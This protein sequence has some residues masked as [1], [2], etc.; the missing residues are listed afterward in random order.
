MFTTFY[1]NSVRNVV[2]AFGSLFNDIYVTRK[3]ADGSTKEKIRVPIAYGPKEKFIRRIYESSSIS[4]GPKVSMTLPRLSFELTS[5]DYD[6]G[7]KRNTMNKR[8]LSSDSGV[9][10]TSFDYS[11]VPYNFS[12]RLSAFV[13][14]MDDGLQIVEQI[15]PYFTPEFNVTVNMNDLHQSVDV[16]VI[17]QSTSIT[18][19]Y[20]GDFDSRRNINFDFEFLTKSFVY[21]PIKTSKII[22]TVNTTFWDTEEFTGSGGVSGATGAL[23]IVQTYATG[24]S[25]AN[26]AIDDYSS[27]DIK[28]V[29]GASMD[30]AGNTYNT[31]P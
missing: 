11:E 31:N 13:R 2:V 30:H 27:D 4:G 20:E 28:W 21:G 12:F 6:S 3:N 25:G 23:S 22:K 26:S 1:H 7:R 24:P 10:S 14:H 18:E 19:D 9:T 5:M 29:Y 17:L 8:F 15:L 16:P